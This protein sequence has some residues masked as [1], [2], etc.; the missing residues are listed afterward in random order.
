MFRQKNFLIDPSTDGR[1]FARHIKKKDKH[2]V[3]F[4]VT[5]K[6]KCTRLLFSAEQKVHFR[7]DNKL[8]VQKV[9]LSSK[10]YN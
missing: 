2:P 5:A 8:F 1:L 9:A 10:M 4:F 7:F 3:S 6:N